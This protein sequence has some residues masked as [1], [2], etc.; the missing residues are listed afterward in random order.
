MTSPMRWR[1][2]RRVQPGHGGRSAG[3]AR[4]VG[5]D[6]HRPGRDRA[7]GSGP[8][9]RPDEVASLLAA[10]DADGCDAR[11][12]T[13]SDVVLEELGAIATDSHVQRGGTLPPQDEL[14]DRVHRPGR[15]PTAPPSERLEAT[16]ASLRQLTDGSAGLAFRNDV[17]HDMAHEA[18]EL[19]EAEYGVDA[20]G[21]EA[22]Q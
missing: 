12:R 5:D 6:V 16:M 19:F 2:R 13:D 17:L 4:V 21:R 3:A 11:I 7:S 9:T 1:W 18:T 20:L 22:R 10:V 8:D 15:E 14:L